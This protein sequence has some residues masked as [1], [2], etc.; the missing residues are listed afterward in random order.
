LTHNFIGKQVIVQVFK[1]FDKLS[2]VSG[3]KVMAKKGE[4]IREIPR[5]PLRL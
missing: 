3:S 5:N 4:Q 2:N 1:G